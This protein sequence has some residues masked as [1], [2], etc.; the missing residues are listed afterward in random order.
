MAFLYANGNLNSPENNTL[1]G[2]GLYPMIAVPRILILIQTNLLTNHG[3]YG[4]IILRRYL[5]T[6]QKE[7]FTYGII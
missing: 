1:Q 5:P 2:G 3:E 6:K 4:I 7:V